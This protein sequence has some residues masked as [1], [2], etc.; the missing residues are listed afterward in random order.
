MHTF[1]FLPFLQ[2]LLKCFTNL[3]L[4]LL[5][6]YYNKTNSILNIV[7]EEILGFYS[8]IYYLLGFPTMSK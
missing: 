3:Y 8:F 7:L 2:L 1:S 5:Y 6:Y 4:L